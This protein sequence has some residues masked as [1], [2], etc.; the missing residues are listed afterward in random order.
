VVVRVTRLA[1]DYVLSWHNNVLF[2]IS[3]LYLP[4]LCRKIS[5]NSNCTSHNFVNSWVHYLSSLYLSLFSLELFYLKFIW[6]HVL[7]I[8]KFSFG[9]L[10][11]V[12]KNL[13]S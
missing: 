8:F 9:M 10:V 4:T 12:L 1:S 13:M 5:L 6:I 11:V 7:M 2:F 3:S